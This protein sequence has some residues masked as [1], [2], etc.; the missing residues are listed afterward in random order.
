MR[1]DFA[2]LVGLDVPADQVLRAVRGADRTLVA[3]AV[4]F[5]VFTGGTLPPGTVSVGIEATLQPRDHTLTEAEITAVSDRIK[6]AV[7]K[8][9]GGTLR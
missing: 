9:T 1:R 2:F 3:E 8:A 4:V 7:L 5:D 6:A